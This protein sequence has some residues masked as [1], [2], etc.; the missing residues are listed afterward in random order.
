MVNCRCPVGEVGEP[1][2]LCMPALAVSVKWFDILLVELG[3]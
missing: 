1:E 3:S 2:A